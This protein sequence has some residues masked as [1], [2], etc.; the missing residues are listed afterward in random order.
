MLV[1]FF[2]SL[3]G[4]K[5]FPQLPHFKHTY[6]KS[7]LFDVAWEY[8]VGDAMKGFLGDWNIVFFFDNETVQN[9]VY[10]CGFMLSTVLLNFQINENE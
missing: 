7:I 2:S 5:P 10:Y 9:M 8:M 3:C 6:L 1:G 4:D